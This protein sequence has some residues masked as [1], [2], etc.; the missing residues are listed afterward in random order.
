M[1]KELEEEKET[2]VALVKAHRHDFHGFL[3]EFDKHVLNGKRVELKVDTIHSGVEE[4]SENVSYLKEL[5]TIS[6]VLK[7][8]KN[9]FTTEIDNR[10]LNKDLKNTR[11]DKRSVPLSV[12]IIVIILIGLIQTIITLHMS[13]YSLEIGGRYPIKIVKT[14]NSADSTQVQGNTKP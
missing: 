5:S 6:G 4:M 1:N 11:E 7:D 8:M 12:F 14:N 13:G 9:A 3:K 2:I 10:E